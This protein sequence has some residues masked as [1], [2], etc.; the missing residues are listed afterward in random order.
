MGAP[1]T[2]DVKVRDVYGRGVVVDGLSRW[3]SRE[4]FEAASHAG[5]RRA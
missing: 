1:R 4:A 3:Q 2:L 5:Q